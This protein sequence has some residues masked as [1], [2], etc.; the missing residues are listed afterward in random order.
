[1]VQTGSN[2]GPAVGHESPFLS[3]VGSGT[4]ASD[5]LNMMNAEFTRTSFRLSRGSVAGR[6]VLGNNINFPIG[7]HVGE[8][9]LL[10]TKV[11]VPI[12]GPV[13]SDVGRLGY[14]WQHQRLWKLL[15]GAPFGGTP[16]K[17]MFWR[18][19]GVK[20]GKRLYY[21]GAGIIERTLVTIGDDCALNEGSLIQGHS[22]EDGT[23]KSGRIVL[24]DRCTV[25]VEAFVHYGVTMGD[26]STVEADAFLMKG[27]DVPYNATY[28]G[29]PAR[30]II[31]PQG[32]QRPA[33]L[34]SGPATGH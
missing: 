19:L 24:G 3:N 25:G 5:G 1:M 15:T 10:G 14:F 32:G 23:F 12:D 2:F 8:N 17:S 26:G 27:E 20:V 29:N 28:V 4:M 34:P 16:F 13:R 33:P 22:L 9:C 6:N 30:E 21:P 18:M 7:A 11:M 31:S